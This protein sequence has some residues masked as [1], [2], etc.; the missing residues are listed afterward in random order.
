MQNPAASPEEALDGVAAKAF[1][2]APVMVICGRNLWISSLMYIVAE[3]VILL[4]VNELCQAMC[5]LF[6]CYYALNFQYPKSKVNG[7]IVGTLSFIQH[8]LFGVKDGERVLG[9]VE[10]LAAVVQ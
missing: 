10:S 1:S 2:T 6:A 7:G 3:G 9:R 8:C 5:M 4:E